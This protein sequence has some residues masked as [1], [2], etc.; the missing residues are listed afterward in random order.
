MTRLRGG[1]LIVCAAFPGGFGLW[2]LYLTMGWPWPDFL[3]PELASNAQGPQ[4][5]PQERVT[6][7]PGLA[8]LFLLAFGG[9][10]GLQGL[11]MLVLGRLNGALFNI[12]LGLF[13]IFG[14]AVLGL[15]LAAQP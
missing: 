9:A 11:G 1:L 7:V 3:P 6:S 2:L 13:A 4:G 10:A 14:V 15:R 8:A 12:L 5:T